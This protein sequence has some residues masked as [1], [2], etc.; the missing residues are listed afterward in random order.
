MASARPDNC[1]PPSRHRSPVPGSL[2]K[3]VPRAILW[4][5][6]AAVVGPT[7]GCGLFERDQPLPVVAREVTGPRIV[8]LPFENA[9]P[10]SDAFFA[11]GMTEE[12]EERL[13]AVTETHRDLGLRRHRHR[14]QR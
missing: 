4:A 14:R 5:L 9:G 13:G 10:E 12:I 6:I 3:W 11:A 2:V 1:S 8:V 7:C